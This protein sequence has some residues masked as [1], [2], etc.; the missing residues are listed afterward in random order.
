MA[1]AENQLGGFQKPRPAS[2]GWTAKLYE[3]HGLGE[4]PSLEKIE[5]VATRL[6]S[7][8]L[9]AIE[10]G[11]LVLGRRIYAKEEDVTQLLFCPTTPEERFGLLLLQK[12]IEEMMKE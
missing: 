6:L 9:T 4:T 8:P 11:E 12:S 2:D 1:Q 3:K 10:A 7:N 5:P